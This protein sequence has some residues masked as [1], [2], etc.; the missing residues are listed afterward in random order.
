MDAKIKQ[1]LDMVRAFSAIGDE[2]WLKAIGGSFS[3]G[4]APAQAKAAL[5][6]YKDVME[7]AEH[8]FE[9]QF[10]DAMDYSDDES[11]SASSKPPLKL[12][13]C[14]LPGIRIDF[15]LFSRLRKGILNLLPLLI[16]MIMR[17]RM[18]LMMMGAQMVRARGAAVIDRNW[19]V[20][21]E[22]NYYVDDDSDYEFK[23]TKDEKRA[24]ADP[25]A[26]D[27]H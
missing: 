25:Y 4:I 7:A 3:Q 14:A 6:R 1:L 22:D 5:K 12:A 24:D 15:K 10:D 19:R 23:V 26:G 9:G 2:C 17:E 21:P 20:A 18:M 8:I 13:V 27:F 11:P 16:L